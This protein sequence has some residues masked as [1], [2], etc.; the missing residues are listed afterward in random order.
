MDVKLHNAYVEVV[1][2]NFL[3][4]VKQNLMF[5]AQLQVANENVKE[6]ESLRN[7]LEDLKKRNVEL[8]NFQTELQVANETTKQIEPLKNQLEDFKKR[9]F[10]LQNKLSEIEKNNI[11][12]KKFYDQN[13]TQKDSVEIVKKEKERIQTALNDS[14]KENKRLKV[15]L[16]SKNSDI[17][18]HNKYI[19]KLESSLPLT[20]LKKI[21]SNDLSQTSSPDDTTEVKTGGVF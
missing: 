2:D 15:E 13:I 3:A 5:Q 6:V 16:E 4:V 10:E 8:Q 7:Q 21:K 17:E 11:E 1:L 9:N 14:L 18:S 20:K 12:L 19:E